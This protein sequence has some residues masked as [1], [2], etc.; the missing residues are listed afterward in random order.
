MTPESI[1]VREL[2]ARSDAV[3]LDV[4]GNPDDMR[5]PGSLRF[6]SDVLLEDPTLPA[7]I[8]RD[9]VI[10]VYCGS[11]NTCR[12]VAAVLRE[13]GYDARALEGG[14]RSWRDAALPLEP[15]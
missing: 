9:A 2:A 13:R 11:G 12:R 15:C 1:G 10:A 7:D 3:I 8:A 6:D 4:R 5:I 14:Y